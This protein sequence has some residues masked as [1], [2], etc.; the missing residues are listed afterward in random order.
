MDIVMTRIE[1]ALA[2]IE[3]ANAARETSAPGSTPDGA[4][5]EKVEKALKELDGLIAELES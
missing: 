5:R 4:I 1:T 2:R 3:A